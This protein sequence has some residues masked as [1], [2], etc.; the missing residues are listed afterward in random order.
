VY[1]IWTGWVGIACIA[2]A[3]AN[4]HVEISGGAVEGCEWKCKSVVQVRA[5]QKKHFE[6]KRAGL[7]KLRG[8]TQREV[9]EEQGHGHLRWRAN[10]TAKKKVKRIG[11]MRAVNVRRSLDRKWRIM[12]RLCAGSSACGCV[13]IVRA[14]G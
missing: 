2:A 5:L 7:E 13:S 9:R 6:Q 3:A 10:K 11:G 12:Q 1:R 14:L 8:Q 4:F